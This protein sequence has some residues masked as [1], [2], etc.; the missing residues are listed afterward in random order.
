MSINRKISILLALGV[1][2]ASSVLFIV[3]PVSDFQQKREELI[4]VAGQYEDTFRNSQKEIEKY[5]SYAKKI[6]DRKVEFQKL[7]TLFRD[8]RMIADKTENTL[9]F[10]GKVDGQFFK[11]ILNF[12]ANTYILEISYFKATNSEKMPVQIRKPKEPS[13][14]IEQMDIKLLEYNANLIKR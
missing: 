8:N 9:S 4:L 14:N 12:F 1:L 10:S 2:I 7:D 11:D 13:I 6:D 5:A 3:L